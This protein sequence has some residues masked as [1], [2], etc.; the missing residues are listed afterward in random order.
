MGW[1]HT[2]KGASWSESAK[3]I[4]SNYEKRKGNGLLIYASGDTV[5]FLVSLLAC[6]R[7]FYIF[8]FLFI[9]LCLGVTQKESLGL[10]MGNPVYQMMI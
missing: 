9:F 4:W 7:L 5:L 2:V 6:K 8:N 1:Q 10:G 3:Q